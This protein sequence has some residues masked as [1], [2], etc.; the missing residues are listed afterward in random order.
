MESQGE[1]RQCSQPLALE[2]AG[3]PDLA[4]RLQVSSALAKNPSW[5]Q[6]ERIPQDQRQLCSFTT[7]WLGA[8]YVASLNLSLLICKM[9][10]TPP[11]AL[12]LAGWR[13]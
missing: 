11:S 12:L 9:D 4:L 10:I 8:N 6:S 5:R 2:G 1:E 7:E 13:D 3:Q